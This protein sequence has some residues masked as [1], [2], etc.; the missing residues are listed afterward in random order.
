[1]TASTTVSH[2]LAE[3]AIVNNDRAFQV[4]WLVYI[5]GIEVPAVSANVSYGVWAIPEAQIAMI[6]DPILQRLG[7]E[8]RVSVQVFY[9]DYWMNPETPE[10]R[11][12]FDGE[13]VSWSYVNV[14]EGR[15][16]SFSC[17][18]YIQIWTQLFFFFMSSINDMA[19]GA[20]GDAIGTTIS[21]V[22]NTGFAPIYPYSLFAQ[23]IIPAANAGGEEGSAGDSSESGV[24]SDEGGGGQGI[25]TRPLDFVYNVVRG[26]IDANLPNRTT[27]ASNFFSPWTRK[28][29]FHKRFIA[30]PYLENSENPGV[31]P[32]LRAVQANFALDAVAQMAS[33]VGN[34]GSIWQILQ[35]IMQTLM[36]EIAMIP[37][38][39]AVVSDY[40]T[41]QVRGVPTGTTS[42]TAP[43]FLTNYMVK[44][45]FFFGIPPV[46]NVFFPTQIQHYAY[47][48][49]YITQPTRMYFNEETLAGYLNVDANAGSALGNMFRDALAV[50][51]PEEVNIAARAALDNP[52]LNG[53]D[54]LVYPEEFFKGPV[55]DRRPL[56]T[57]FSFLGQAG[58]QNNNPRPT[59][60]APTP[61]TPATPAVDPAESASSSSEAASDISPGDTDRNVFRLY[62]KYEYF[63][64]RYS[65]RTG[66][67]SLL[68][69]PYPVPGFPCAVFD[70]RSTQ[71]DTFGYIMS[72]S[73]SLRSNGWSTNV[74]FT[75]GRTFQEMFALLQS[76]FTFENELLT[77]QQN[78]VMSEA[79]GNAS[80]SVDPRE[81][82]T[83]LT[84]PVGAIA[85]AP[86]E[87][88]SEIRDVIQNFVRAEEFYA[89]LFFRRVG[90]NSGILNAAQGIEGNRVETVPTTTTETT[91]SSTPETPLERSLETVPD[92]APDVVRSSS[93]TPTR[94]PLPQD[95]PA[96][97]NNKRASF[98]YPDIITLE[99]PATGATEDVSITGIDST[100]REAALAALERLR[101]GDKSQLTTDIV[102][103]S[104]A[105]GVDPSTV[106]TDTAI[107]PA[108]SATM[109]PT[110]ATTPTSSPYLTPEIEAMVAAPSATITTAAA[111][112]T[113]T[114]TTTGVT[115]SSTADAPAPVATSASNEVFAR[116]ETNIRTRTTTSNLRGDAYVRPKPE[117]M[118]L[119][120]S[121]E[122]AMRYC[123]RPICT[124][125]EYIQFLGNYGTQGTL[126]E[127]NGARLADDPRMFP[128]KYYTSI[129]TYRNGPPTTL[130]NT[131][132]TN[133]TVVT[134]TTGVTGAPVETSSTPTAATA[135]AAAVSTSGV[136]ATSTA[137]TDATDSNTG[138]AVVSGLPDDFPETRSN[139]SAILLDY[140][141]RALDSIVPRT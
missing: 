83:N 108:A 41:L 117:A 65:R 125:D 5:N 120:E 11:L 34:A 107:A 24:T 26:L 8:D 119:F 96:A 135:T 1:M 16:L 42:I 131:N 69:N 113:G 114:T 88:L 138:S 40:S 53:K 51:Y 21:S 121:Y 112:S 29:N 102:L 30:L 18:D 97:T 95:T 115:A 20:S 62:A 106:P 91:V 68:F 2:D 7:A 32:V 28:T 73:Q 19:T 38:P 111:I 136:S 60:P 63:K 81:P 137:D 46:C 134:D 139:W 124:L 17:V 10:F 85:T 72:V 33:R 123:A 12:M 109:T 126:V 133:T 57:W 87:P 78:E 127:P 92:L 48:E 100:A 86:A 4:A 58:V 22:V 56:P 59:T 13:I 140:R 101:T 116:L 98:Y 47:E 110:A 90:A 128:A 23:G 70:R 6:P 80:E 94:D 84:N 141:R 50:A 67:L 103:I 15:T 66:A 49:N 36:M 79:R 61:T 74:S 14:Q 99:D 45:P 132:I 89:E 35:E 75:H 27:P 39:A 82:S 31:F 77:L 25:I 64:E 104:S 105:A 43:V 37:T 93:P 122:S 3:D 76:Q 130:P 54:I 52:G 71:V 9:C 118:P 129:R 55:V 44:P